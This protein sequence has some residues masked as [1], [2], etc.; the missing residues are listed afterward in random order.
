M[1]ITDMPGML[2]QQSGGLFKWAFAVEDQLVGAQVEANDPQP[3]QKLIAE[4]VQG[5]HETRRSVIDDH[6]G[7]RLAGM[8]RLPQPVGGL[9]GDRID[10]FVRGCRKRLMF[11]T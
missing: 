7:R 2:L 10:L 6:V 5:L 4:H 9:L 8:D 11:T 1:L 3:A